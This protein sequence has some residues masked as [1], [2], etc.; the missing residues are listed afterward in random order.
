MFPD[1]GARFIESSS[2]FCYVAAFHPVQ[3]PLWFSKR[4]IPRSDLVHPEP[5]LD[6]RLANALID[7]IDELKRS[8]SSVYAGRS[9]E[10]VVAILESQIKSIKS[11]QSFDRARLETLFGPTG[12][13]QEHAMDNGWSKKY[14]QI[15]E[16]VD[17]CI[18]AD[19]GIGSPVRQTSYG[20]VRILN[21]TAITILQIC[22]GPALFWL[23]PNWLFST[24]SGGVIYY[25]IPFLSGF[26]LLLLAFSSG[27]RGVVFALILSISGSMASALILFN[28]YGT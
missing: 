13:I 1:V 7:A 24:F 4:R 14:M 28:Y 15:C 5:I 10:E 9:V 26:V 6:M 22:L 3:M 25:A 16:I 23:K 11:A 12:S 8:K 19:R 21:V 27:L 2:F 17:E 18:D 20:I